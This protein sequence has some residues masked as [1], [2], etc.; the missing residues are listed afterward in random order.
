MRLSTYDAII[1]RAELTAASSPA[2]YRLWVRFFAGIGFSIASLAMF[3]GI[4]LLVVAIG[5]VIVAHLKGQLGEGTLKMAAVVAFF[6]V[7]LTWSLVKGLMF[8]FPPVAGITLKK[9][10]ASELFD[11]VERLRRSLQVP[12]VHR[13]ILTND[14]NAMLYQRP[15]LGIFGWYDNALILGLPLLRQFGVDEARSIIAHELGHLHGEH[16]RSAAK[17]YRLRQTWQTLIE[18]GGSKLLG[19]FMSW[20]VPRFNAFTFVLARMHEREADRMSAELCSP[21]A[22]GSALVRINLIGRQ[23]PQ[24][25]DRLSVIAAREPHVP[26]NIYDRLNAALYQPSPDVRRWLREEMTRTNNRQDTHPCLSERLQI[27]GYSFRGTIPDPPN[28]GNSAADHWLENPT[29]MTAAFNTQWQQ[30][31]ADQWQRS[32]EKGARL[33]AKRDALQARCL[34]DDIS[35]EDHWELISLTHHFDG[36]EAARPM[37][38]AFIALYPRNPPALYR[39]GSDLLHEGDARGIPFIEAAMFYDHDAVASGCLALRDFADAY[40]HRDLVADAE[41]R[42][43]SHRDLEN[44]A[45]AE[46]TAIPEPNA[47]LP[48]ELSEQQITLVS[49]SLKPHDDIIAADVARVQTR[50]LPER[51]HY[52]VVLHLTTSWWSSRDDEADQKLI[53]TVMNSVVFPG[54]CLMIFAHKQQKLATALAANDQARVFSRVTETALDS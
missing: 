45:D 5:I 21:A 18:R 36:P 14:L 48:H 38:S 31:N 52:L 12:P 4:M 1:S 19:R 16:G 39:L 15:R 44:E 33:L 50:L 23:Y 30:E 46:R 37:L 43:E 25:W 24:F 6:G 49:E 3:S 7:S 54:T 29:Q 13:I 35:Q 42:L 2:K 53:N 9:E 26:T 27:I 8:G 41:R 22:A 28:A 11:E 20:Y 40:G 32:H 51:R 34:T 47:L 10:D 17:I